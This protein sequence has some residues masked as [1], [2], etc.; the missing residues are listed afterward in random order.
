MLT[1]HA[2]K[3]VSKGPLFIHCGYIEPPCC[4]S[5]RI[6]FVSCSARRSLA[7]N[8]QPSSKAC[9]M[10]IRTEERNALTIQRQ[11]PC[12]SDGPGGNAGLQPR[13]RLHSSSTG[14]RSQN[15]GTRRAGPRTSARHAPPVLSCG[16]PP[17]GEH[18]LCSHSQV[19][20][21]AKTVLR[22]TPQPPELLDSTRNKAPANIL[23]TVLRLEHTACYANL[24]DAG[25][26]RV[27]CSTH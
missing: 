17:G 2:L 24:A 10:A 11:Q 8:S 6:D 21:A 20:L 16:P 15:G 13:W 26:R 7:H 9:T 23:C 4:S 1:G 22:D 3:G 5:R 25:H 19:C 12:R 27:H 18:N 14:Q